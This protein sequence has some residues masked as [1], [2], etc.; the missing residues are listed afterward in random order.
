MLAALVKQYM[1]QTTLTSHGKAAL[2][3]LVSYV[4]NHNL[5]FTKLEADDWRDLFS[6]YRSTNAIVIQRYRMEVT[7][8]YHWLADNGLADVVNTAA[9]LGDKKLLKSAIVTFDKRMFFPDYQTMIDA[10][11]QSMNKASDEAPCSIA[12]IGTYL[13]LAWFGFS[14]E[15]MASLRM[16]DLEF[17]ADGLHVRDRCIRHPKAIEIIKTYCDESG[18]DYKDGT[19][20]YYKYSSYLFRSVVSDKPTVKGLNMALT[21]CNKAISSSN[22]IFSHSTVFYS[23]VYAKTFDG[24]RLYHYPVL[25]SPYPPARKRL[26]QMFELTKTQLA[27]PHVFLSYYRNFYAWCKEYRTVDA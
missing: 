14:V 2:N 9:I 7:K 11:E 1:E 21:R 20:H 23:A 25:P 26:E 27:N 22:V 5:D 15:E 16:T 4:K 8:F 19:F 6:S 10:L 12:H 18:V 13:T 17:T 24:M 3:G